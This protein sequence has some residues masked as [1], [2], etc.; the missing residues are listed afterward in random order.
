MGDM[1]NLL[2][3]QMLSSYGN[4]PRDSE[5]KDNTT[6]KINAIEN[7][8]SLLDYMEKRVQG[9]VS[10]ENVAEILDQ[11]AEWQ[12]SIAVLKKYIEEEFS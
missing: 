3:E 11:T 2:I 4:I 7:L 8:R 1:D 5:R 12:K 10:Q 9:V 6:E